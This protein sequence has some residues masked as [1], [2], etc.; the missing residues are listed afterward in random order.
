ME[1]KYL[2]KLEFNKVLEMLENYAV[3]YLGKELVKDLKPSFNKNEVQITLKE[4]E[5][6]EVLTHRI[7]GIPLGE[8]DNINVHLRTLEAG[9]TL[10][11]KQLLDLAKT[12]KISR[13]LKEYYEK[14]SEIENIDTNRLRNYFFS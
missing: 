4:T 7:G 3:T 10:S 6:A 5:Q 13:E 12:L 9:G 1:Q 8:I 2:D 11:I 14:I